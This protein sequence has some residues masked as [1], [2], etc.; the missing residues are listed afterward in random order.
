MKGK[1]KA[2]A[3]AKLLLSNRVDDERD[4]SGS[5]IETAGKSQEEEVNRE[6]VEEVEDGKDEGGEEEGDDEGEG[7]GG[8]EEEEE[9][10]GGEA[11]EEERP[12]LDEGFYEMEAIRQ[13]RSRKGQIQYLI[14]WRGWPEAANTWEPK[15]NLM[16][17]SDV[18]EAFEERLGSGKGTRKRKRKH[19]GSHLQGKKKQ[20]RAGGSSENNVTGDE[21]S[22][23]DR[24]LPSTS[25]NTSSLASPPAHIQEDGDNGNGNGND[26]SLVQV[27]DNGCTSR[28][29]GEYDPK[30][31]E[32]RGAATSNDPNADKIAFQ[33]PPP[34]VQNGLPTVDSV[35]PAQN[36]RRPGSRRRKSS[37][38][39]RFRENPAACDPALLDNPL[40]NLSFSCSSGYKTEDQTTDSQIIK[41]L[42]PISFS[43]SSCDSIQDVVVTFLAMR[44]DGKE[45]IVDN[46]ILKTNNP[47]LVIQLPKMS[48]FI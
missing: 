38:V 19:G 8:G 1:R 41:I 5:A 11:E 21:V 26:G 29:E 27:G 31:S 10:G 24:S 6:K 4:P 13:K 35:D 32:L 22:G 17:C 44:S 45:V 28:P 37:S 16:S 33:F 20:Q 30:L 14:K 46:K 47:L 7:G 39:K 23:A 18:I 15:E 2:S 25:L 3:N 48:V 9:D 42:K 34:E 40:S 43:A 12:K 36:S